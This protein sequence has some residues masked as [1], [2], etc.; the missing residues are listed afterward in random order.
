MGRDKSCR[1]IQYFI[2]F[3]VPML[4]KQ[5]PRYLDLKERL[6]LLGSNMS[7]TRKVLR[8]GKP[9]PLVKGIMDR[10]K[11]HEKKP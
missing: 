1:V 2:K 8:F 7:L 4:A 6:E 3:L 10:I 11:E 5:G 9:I